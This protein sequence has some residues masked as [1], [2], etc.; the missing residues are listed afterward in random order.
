[1]AI[2][3]PY[4]THLSV[5]WS[6]KEKDLMFGGPSKVDCRLVN[7]VFCLKRARPLTVDEANPFGLFDPDFIHDLEA[8]GY[9]ITTLRFSVER[10][11]TS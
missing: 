4:D 5:W 11:A 1:M 10:K 9:D 2:H 8:R 3:P 6:K 7:N